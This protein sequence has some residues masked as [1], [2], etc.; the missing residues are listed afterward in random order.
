MDRPL[1]IKTGW[2]SV[3]GLMKPPAHQSSGIISSYNQ[4]KPES[5]LILAADFLGSLWIQR[6]LGWTQRK[7]SSCFWKNKSLHKLYFHHPL[8]PHCELILI[9]YHSLLKLSITHNSLMFRYCK[10]RDIFE[11]SMQFKFDVNK[12]GQKFENQKRNLQIWPSAN[13]HITTKKATPW[14]CSFNLVRMKGL[15]LFID[16]S[17][18]LRHAVCVPYQP[19]SAL[20]SK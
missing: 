10:R 9:S 11:K 8:Y 1:P 5:G 6:F 20:I 16:F 15:S 12:R 14:R 2:W 13:N 3:N 7:A 4:N 17:L 19:F 18:W